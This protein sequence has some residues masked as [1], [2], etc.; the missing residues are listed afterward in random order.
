MGYLP[1]GRVPNTPPYD[2]RRTRLGRDRCIPPLE[3]FEQ[4]LVASASARSPAAGLRSQLSGHEQKRMCGDDD[5]C[6]FMTPKETLSTPQR[7]EPQPG[8]W[9]VTTSIS[10]KRPSIHPSTRPQFGWQSHLEPAARELV[11]KMPDLSHSFSPSARATP[12][13]RSSTRTMTIV[14]TIRIVEAA[15]ISGSVRVST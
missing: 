7:S 3:K 14:A 12:I 6:L 4:R 15:A 8:S 13:L 1:G 10:L 2:P 9:R 11:I 5:E